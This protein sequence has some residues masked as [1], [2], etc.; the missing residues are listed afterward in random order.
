[1]ACK[2]NTDNGSSARAHRWLLALLAR[3]RRHRRRVHASFG[4]VDLHRLAERILVL[5]A[6]APRRFAEGGDQRH[7]WG[8][9]DTTSEGGA[10]VCARRHARDAF[11]GAVR[12]VRTHAHTQCKHAAHNPDA[13]RK[14]QK[15]TAPPP[16]RQRCAHRR[17]QRTPPA[18]A[19]AAVSTGVARLP[20]HNTH[21]SFAAV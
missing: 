3:R 20:C 11:D 10:S 9:G 7:G 17:S 8:G 4:F 18:A 1:M 15:M 12:R 14:P 5:V 21:Y 16:E 2:N 19:V 13:P 6:G